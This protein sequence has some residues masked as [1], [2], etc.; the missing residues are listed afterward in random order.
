MS[1]DPGQGND[2]VGGRGSL[3][4]VVSPTHRARSDEANARRA[5]ML[6]SLIAAGHVHAS[7][8]RRA[9]DRVARHEFVP[10][11][12]L[13]EAY[14]PTDAVVIKRDDTGAAVSSAS[15]PNIVAV[16]LDQAEV[17]PGHRV[18]EIGTGTG[19]N[20]ALLAE[21]AGQHGHVLSV[22]IDPDV[23]E[24]A[25]AALTRTGYRGVTTVAHD[26]TVPIADQEPFDRIIVTAGAWD[27]PP[28][29]FRQLRPGGR[30]VVPLRWRGQT[31]SVALV[32]PHA[33]STPERPGSSA[34]M[35][36]ATAMSCCGFI[37]MVGPSGERTTHLDRDGQV[38][39][40]WDVDQD[41]RPELLTDVLA[42]RREHRWSEVMIS[43]Q[44]PI[45]RI[46]L[47]LTAS[48]PTTCRVAATSTAI[49]GGLP[50]PVLPARAAAL[51]EASSL[52]YLT[53]RAHGA[54]SPGHQTL[55]LGAVGYG[56]HG[57]QLAERI[58]EHITAWSS[59]RLAHPELTVHPAD[60]D[61]PTGQTIIKTHSRLALRI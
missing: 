21:I 28:A 15:A 35:L 55:E 60:H 20:A 2:R 44:E 33:P 41:I 13:S 14:A 6:E 10:E 53:V 9:L 58:V 52:S 29:W 42:H 17:A 38:S 3:W 18:L 26:G 5:D 23:V 47:R 32:A 27:I 45:D 11:V 34:L 4:V 56:P 49:R 50:A 31:Q 7:S 36:R 51:A 12:S 19:Y 46:W 25:R 54:A 30:L 8:V 57:A 24:R 1:S 59:D 16:M 43:G 40:T 48:E 39:L 22:D 37:P 61:A